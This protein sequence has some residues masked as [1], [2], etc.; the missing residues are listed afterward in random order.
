MKHLRSFIP[1]RWTHRG[2]Q[3]VRNGPRNINL[4][5]G[6]QRRMEEP[7]FLGLGMV[8]RF[9]SLSRRSPREK[10][11]G[12]TVS[13][14]FSSTFW[15]GFHD[16][17]PRYVSQTWD[18]CVWEGQLLGTKAGNH[19]LFLQKTVETAHHCHGYC[20]DIAIPR[21]QWVPVF[22]FSRAKGVESRALKYQKPFGRYQGPLG[23]VWSWGTGNYRTP[24]SNQPII[25]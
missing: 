23:A 5:L 19:S 15:C 12:P 4:W 10:H 14:F 18:E 1:L 24:L 9:A 7:G 25:G 6:P 11:V 2:H 3:C 17:W 13:V 21:Q 16:R 20:I 22:L 8:A